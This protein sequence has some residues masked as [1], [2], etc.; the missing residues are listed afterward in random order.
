[1]IKI[2]ELRKILTEECLTVRIPKVN[3]LNTDRSI[4]EV[5][6]WIGK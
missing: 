3:G 1:M 5:V 4:I 2:F 6:W